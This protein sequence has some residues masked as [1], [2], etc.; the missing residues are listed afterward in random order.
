MSKIQYITHLALNSKYK[1][2]IHITLYIIF[3]N[4][5]T[6]N[7]IE[8]MNQ[9]P[10]TIVPRPIRPFEHIRNLEHEISQLYAR[11]D[12]LERSL[13]YNLEQRLSE[14]MHY[15]S[16]LRVAVGEIHE[17]RENLHNSYQTIAETNQLVNRLL[18]ENAALRHNVAQETHG[19]IS[20]RGLNN[21]N[22]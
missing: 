16:L 12:V 8:C 5:L 4:L 3:Y 21:N 14:R 19:Y 20:N 9:D 22:T 15:E 6:C 2:F 11:I 18:H 10:P 7:I 13:S 17:L 1:T